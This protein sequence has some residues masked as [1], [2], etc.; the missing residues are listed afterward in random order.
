MLELN[1]LGDAPSRS[2]YREALVGY[3]SD[4]RDALSADSRDRL[5]RNPLRIL[6]SK[7]VGDRALVVNAP[8]IQAVLTA[9]AAAFYDGLR[10]HLDRLRVPFRE[11][12]RIVRGLDY[13]NHTAFEFVTDQ[14]GAQGTDDGRRGAMTAWSRR[15]AA[16]RSPPSAGPPGWSGWP[17][18]WMRRLHRLRRSR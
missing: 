6:D 5:E 1:T 12:P 3:F 7:D 14:L 8:T 17:C 13:Y 10:S 4:H 16:R 18:C 11:N 2:A 9:E 15:W